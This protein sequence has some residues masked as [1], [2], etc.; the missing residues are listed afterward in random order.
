MPTVPDWARIANTT[1]HE[2]IRDE[3]VN[4]IRN[5][6]L[7]AMLKE[8]GRITFNHSG[9]I[10]DWKV[11][12]KRA[13]MQGYADTDTLTFSRRNRW[14]T[15]QLDWRGYSATDSMTK[16]E[17]L[18]NKGQEA[19]IK[20]ASQI[21]ESLMEDLD[22]QFGDELYIDGSAA[23]NTKRV[24]GL[25]TLFSS[26]A[27]ANTQSPI[28]LPANTYAGLV[29]TL[30]NYGGSW[31]QVSGVT[32]WPSGTGDA[33]YDFWSPLPVSYTS[34]NAGTAGWAATTKTWPNTCREAL[35]FGITYAKKNASRKSVLDMILLNAD[36]WR[37][38][39]TN[40]DAE[41]RIVVDSSTLKKLGF[42]DVVNFD[43][44]DVAQEYGIPAAVGY[45]LCIPQ[46]EL[47]S[48]QGQ[49]FEADPIDFDIASQS[50]RFNVSFFGNLRI[51]PRFQVKFAAYG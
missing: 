2:Y 37:Q 8:R 1:I 40:S 49:V 11:R 4:I 5:R 23:G 46:M 16:M 28:G 38:F 36:L 22:D 44:C 18:K 19:I 43:G 12:Y 26:V 25:E 29:T 47:R 42:R 27:S 34:A 30:G 9:D 17:R 7:L 24:H 35:R 33:H 10:M 20:I 41:E 21:V 32:T 39:L 45:G 3:E 48:L 50:N 14:Q 6:K 51:N 15:A 13:P 31:S